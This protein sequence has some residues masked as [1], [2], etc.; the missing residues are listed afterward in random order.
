MDSPFNC[1]VCGHEHGT[2]IL[3]SC[4][5][6]YAGT[7]YLVDYWR[8]N[9]CLL[10]QQFPLPSDTTLFYK[11]Y[12]VH[13]KK[14]PLFR[15]FR[16]LLMSKSYYPVQTSSQ[17][18]RLLDFGCGDGWFLESCRNKNLSLLGYERDPSHAR[19]LSNALGIRIESDISTLLRNEAK[20]IDI[21][22]MNFVVEH[23]TDL[24][25]TFALASQLVKPDGIFY[26]SVP[27]FDAPEHRLF[28]RKWHSLDAPR[29]ISF[30]PPSVVSDLARKHGMALVE[31][32]NLPFLTDFAASLAVAIRGRFSYP[33]FLLSLPLSLVF[34]LF[35]R[36]SAYGYWLRRETV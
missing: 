28:G 16:H 10:A 27:N 29:H 35:S 24:H 13:A 7:P 1:L 33:L 3:E 23:L 9:A 12:P 32:R 18:L 22:T 2:R 36:R 21:L 14:S 4:P 34:N 20:S 30:P 19:N 15:V 11:N 25:A 17:E 8:C 26:F 31:T 6:Y 5:D